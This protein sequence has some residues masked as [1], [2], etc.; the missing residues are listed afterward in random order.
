MINANDCIENIDDRV[1][2]IKSIRSEKSK[3]SAME[4]ELTEPFI[5]DLTQ[6]ESIYGVFQKYMSDNKLEDTTMNRQKFIFVVLYLY[7]VGTLAGGKM[8]VGVRDMIA[9]VTGCSQTLIS[10]NCSNVDFLYTHY[11]DFKDGVLEILRRVAEETSINIAFR[12]TGCHSKGYKILMS[13][14]TEKNVEDICVGDMVMGDDMTP[15]IVTFVH[16]GH[17]RLMKVKPAKGQHF[18]VNEGHILSLYS[19]K[20]REYVELTAL[21]Y[22]HQT[23]Q[24]KRGLMLH[25][26]TGELV[27]FDVYRTRKTDDYYGFSVDGNHLYLDAQGF[28]HHNYGMI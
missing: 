17:G 27:R 6:I 5:D 15:R 4:S 24:Y 14:G 9:K 13:D 10:H 8:K 1:E 7:S 2:S 16:R 20:S 28:V 21:S 11:K 22:Y 12:S 26:E 23:T 25:T 19:T 18:M 3:L